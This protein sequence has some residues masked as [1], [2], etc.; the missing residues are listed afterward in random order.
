MICSVAVV[1]NYCGLSDLFFFAWQAFLLPLLWQQTC[2]FHRIGSGHHR[3]LAP[4]EQHIMYPG[5]NDRC[6]EDK[7]FSSRSCSGCGRPVCCPDRQPAE[8]R[9]EMRASQQEGK[10]SILMWSPHAGYPFFNCLNYSSSLLQLEWLT[11]LFVKPMWIYISV[12]VE[13]APIK[14]LGTLLNAGYV[15]EQNNTEH[16]ESKN[17]NYK[18]NTTTYTPEWLQTADKTSVETDMS[19]CY[20]HTLLVR[21]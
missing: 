21:V 2:P 10:S 18:W 11:L 4:H 20:P 3:L 6:W 17:K 5:P 9:A 19:N 7:T 1:W 13:R 15:L 12:C 16:Q 8:N 14:T